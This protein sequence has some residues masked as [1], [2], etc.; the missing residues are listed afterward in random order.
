MTSEVMFRPP[1][2]FVTTVETVQIGPQGMPHHPHRSEI[3]EYGAP[4]AKALFSTL[5]KWTPETRL[6]D[7]TKIE[8]Q[9]SKM[10]NRPP[11]STSWRI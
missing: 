1:R 10:T 5:M 11:L 3:S 6:N 9:Y 8:M 4:L 7:R 2:Q